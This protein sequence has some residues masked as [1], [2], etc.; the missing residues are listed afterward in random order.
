MSKEA[1]SASNK[2]ATKSKVESTSSNGVKKENKPQKKQPIP[3]DD[4]LDET[5]EQVAA[6]KIGKNNNGIPKD[7]NGGMPKDNNGGMP[8]DNNG[9]IPKNNNGIA[10]NNEDESPKPKIRERVTT[11]KEE[12]DETIAQVLAQKGGKLTDKQREQATS[13][14][15]E[16]LGFIDGELSAIKHIRVIL[17]LAKQYSTFIGSADEIQA[18]IKAIVLINNKKQA[19]KD[20]AIK[21]HLTSFYKLMEIKI[22]E[23]RKSNLNWL[24][25]KEQDII[26]T[27]GRNKTA[28]LPL[29]GL[30]THLNSL[31]TNQGV[32]DANSLDYELWCLFR[33]LSYAQKA[34]A[35]DGDLFAE[36]AEEVHVSN[37]SEE[38][39]G[40]L[41]SSIRDKVLNDPAV[42]SGN[43]ETGTV[44]NSVI[45]QLQTSPEIQATLANIGTNVRDGNFDFGSLL[46]SV[47]SGIQRS[48]MDEAARKADEGTED[49]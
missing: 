15:K 26:I 6:M 10:K 45:S 1:T 5:M 47:M 31:T 32:K 12:L 24:H 19:E 4:E 40:D 49:E 18:Y 9:G 38:M 11:S 28:K 35:K 48:P 29:S 13:K 27:Y 42:A 14:A 46:N 17:T 8:K 44:V 33:D 37:E 34:N 39:V 3:S 41:S 22:G 7:N 2:P 36:N 23:L 16:M 20:K 43:Y 30:Y 21:S 25:S